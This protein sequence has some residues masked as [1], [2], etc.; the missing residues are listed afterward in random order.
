MLLFLICDKEKVFFS[1]NAALPPN[2]YV[3][4]DWQLI[5]FYAE[6]WILY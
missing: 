4:R 3:L 6:I 5:K 2:L 1:L